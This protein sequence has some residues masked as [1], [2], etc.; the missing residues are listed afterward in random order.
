MKELK[1]KLVTY[2]RLET[3]FEKLENDY[4]D[5]EDNYKRLLDAHDDM[6]KDHAEIVNKLGKLEGERVEERGEFLRMQ[7]LEQEG[8]ETVDAF[9]RKFLMARS[10]L[11]MIIIVLLACFFI[12]MYNGLLL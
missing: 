11:F 5:L 2:E 12:Y 9:S 10:F 4:A 7:R 6:E 3:S 8:R 1:D